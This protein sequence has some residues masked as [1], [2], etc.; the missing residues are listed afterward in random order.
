MA[1]RPPGLWPSLSCRRHQEP[2]QQFAASFAA[3]CS[4]LAAALEAG[5]LLPSALAAL[6]AMEVAFAGLWEGCSGQERGK[7]LDPEAAGGPATVSEQ[8]QPLDALALHL[9]LS[10]LFA[11]ST[12]AGRGRCMC[13]ARRSRCGL[14]CWLFSIASTGCQQE[15]W[16]PTTPAQRPASIVHPQLPYLTPQVR[17]IFLVL[18]GALGKDCPAAAALVRAHLQS[19]QQWDAVAAAQVR[20]G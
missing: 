15:G 3:C 6:R 4:E 2:L 11:A 1:A 10:L 13:E 8:A 12:Q 14:L 16:R 20:Q 17:R 7:T 5:T 18:P 19:A 9:A